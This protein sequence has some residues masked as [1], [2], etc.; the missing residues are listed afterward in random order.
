MK[1]GVKV[2]QL[3]PLLEVSYVTIYRKL[4]RMKKELKGK[5]YKENGILFLLPDAVEIIKNSL[6]KTGNN[7]TDNKA[8]NSIKTVTEQLLK[9]QLNVLKDELK[10]KDII[11]NK[12]MENNGKLI[13]KHS[14]ER[15][16]S[17]TIIMKLTQDVNSLQHETKRLLEDARPPLDKQK[18][19]EEYQI[20]KCEK[21]VKNNQNNTGKII[22]IKNAT[23][24]SGNINNEQVDHLERKSF[25]K[26]LYIRLFKPELLR[27]AN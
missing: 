10:R 18:Q 5:V 23:K 6:I 26:R 25:L 8:L 9:E 7:I 4:K 13:E 11:M 27:K 22:P 16:R 17:D 12:L 2:S 14:Q 24:F 19:S 20:G 21:V 15:E 1:K 3:V